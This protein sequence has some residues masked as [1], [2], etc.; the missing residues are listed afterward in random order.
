MGAVESA[1]NVAGCPEGFTHP[2]TPRNVETFH[3]AAGVE[4]WWHEAQRAC[5]MGATSESKTG[6]C[7]GPGRSCEHDASTHAAAKPRRNLRIDNP[8]Y[9]RPLGNVGGGFPVT[10]L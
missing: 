6:V 9:G 7:G 5:K 8:F 1:G 2:S 4:P 10:A 3:P